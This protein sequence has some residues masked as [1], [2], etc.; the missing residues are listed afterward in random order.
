MFPTSKLGWTGLRLR[1]AIHRR[2]QLLLFLCTHSFAHSFPLRKFSYIVALDLADSVDINNRWTLQLNIVLIKKLLSVK[3]HRLA[4][5][6]VVTEDV[7]VSFVFFINVA[8]PWN[9]YPWGFVCLMSDFLVFFNLVF[10]NA[11][12][13]LISNMLAWFYAAAHWSIHGRIYWFLNH[14]LLISSLIQ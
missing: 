12:G 3:F 11:F 5:H 10:T 13:T 4:Q 14:F 9:L 2:R 8:D 1:E 7:C 6:S